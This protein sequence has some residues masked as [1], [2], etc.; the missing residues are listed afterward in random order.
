MII[1]HKHI[2]YL[3]HHHLN[4]KLYCFCI[5]SFLY[6]QFVFLS[7]VG[8][9]LP[10]FQDSIFEYFNTSPLAHDLTF[11]VSVSH[12]IW[13]MHLLMHYCITSLKQASLCPWHLYNDLRTSEHQRTS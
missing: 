3:N 2:C 12:Y 4:F 7:S 13:L 9:K 6:L 1:N 8:L 10:D 5:V 11:R